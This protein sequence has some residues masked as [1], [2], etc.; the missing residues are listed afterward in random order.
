MYALFFLLSKTTKLKLFG[1]WTYC[2]NHLTSFIDELLAPMFL[3]EVICGR[4]TAARN[5]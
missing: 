5:I 1:S 3:N 2:R 4:G